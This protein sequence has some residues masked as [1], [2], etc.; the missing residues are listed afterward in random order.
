MSAERR[1]YYLEDDR[2][3]YRMRDLIQLVETSEQ[4]FTL[5]HGGRGLESDYLEIKAHGKGR[6]EH[7]PGL[8]L[9][10]HYDTAMKYAK[11]GGKLYRVTIRLGTN[12]EDVTIPLEDA[13]AFVQRHVVS[14]MRPQMIR[15]LQSNYQR[16]GGKLRAEVL[17]NLCLNLSA[18][19][20]SKTNALRQ[21]LID[22]G[23]DYAKTRYGG[24]DETVVVVINPRMIKKVEV[25]RAG[26]VQSDEFVM[27]APETSR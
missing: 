10:T 14:R 23:V 27:P 26:D 6:W 19:P 13:L 18:I 11:G 24:R 16:M 12:I 3:K 4:T 8:Y 15:D 5:W 7:G 1:Q 9:T 20:N 2:P 25:V 21:F 17:V 22:H